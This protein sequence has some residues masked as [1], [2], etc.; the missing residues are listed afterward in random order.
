MSPLSRL[1]A[2]F[3]FGRQHLDTQDCAQRLAQFSADK[4]STSNHAALLVFLDQ[5][6]LHAVHEVQ[7]Q[8][9]DIQKVFFSSTCMEL[10]IAHTVHVYHGP[11]TLSVNLTMPD[12]P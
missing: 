3:V 10:A 11:L 7:K 4:A 5:V 9:H 1:P 2:Y 6:L 12:S 8:L